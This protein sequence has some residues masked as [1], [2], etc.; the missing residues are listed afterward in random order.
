MIT[1]KTLPQATTQE[2]FD[3]IALHLLVQN[4]K[5]RDDATGCCLYRNVDGLKCAAGCL[6]DDGEYGEE[7]EHNSWDVLVGAGLVPENNWELIRDLQTIHDDTLPYDWPDELTNLAK[8]CKLSYRVVE[9]FLN[10]QTK[11]VG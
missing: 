1:L 6:I 9:D 2:V 10:D 8:K 4:A 7:L 5:S 11:T 3:Q